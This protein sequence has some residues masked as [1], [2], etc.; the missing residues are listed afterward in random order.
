MIIM[1]VKKLVLKNFK[2]FD[3]LTIDLGEN[4]KKIIALI[5][6][7]GC[8][9][10]S[11]FDAFE[12]KLKQYK[13]ANKGRRQINFFSKLWF[14][15]LP[16]RRTE[17]YSV[18]DSIKIIKEDETTVFNK[19]SFYVRSSYRFTPEL[20]AN[21]I[22]T[23]PDVINDSNRPSSSIDLDSRLLENYERLIS[24]SWNEWQDGNKTGKEMREELLGKINDIL[25]RIIDIKISNLGNIVE[26][27]GQLF[28]EKESSKDFPF[29]N[30]SSGEKE[31]VDFIIDL[32]V[33]TPEFNDTVYCIDEPELHLN[34]AIQRRLLIEIEKLIP[35]NCQLWIATHSIGFLRALQSDLKEK[36]SILDFSERDYFNSDCIITPLKVNRKNWQRIFQTALDDLTGLVAPKQIIYCEGNPTPS[37]SNEE[38]GLD[39]EIYNQIFSSYY[40][41]TL[42][43]SSGGGS[44]L[45]RNTSIAL[46]VLNKAFKDCE[47]I[48]LKDRDHITDDERQGFLNSN[49]YNRMLKRREIENYIFDRE[50][51]EKYCQENNLTFNFNKYNDTVTDINIQDLKPVQQ[52]IQHSCENTLKIKDFKLNLAKYITPDTYVYKEL[53]DIIFQVSP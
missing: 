41:D 18:N 4:P 25:S 12:E 23:L 28:F 7:N 33:K 16:D 19:K 17:Q 22:K 27:K 35:E 29:E 5:G 8:G 47:L 36:C 45:T 26:G 51:L 49:H 14:S 9:K 52:A 39:A 34:T 6:P 20:K 50:I 32:I 31:V 46:K 1:K 48:L 10:S 21:N 43:I 38:Q 11:I 37:P 30:L 44:E 40:P 15:I 42:F 24:M 2:R 3:N 13:S 53:L